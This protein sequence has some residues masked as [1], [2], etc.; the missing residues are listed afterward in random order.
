MHTHIQS[1]VIVV[2]NASTDGS[3]DMVKKEFP[4]VKLIESDK[5]LG[6]GLGNNLGVN[7]AVGE[8][9]MLFNSDALLTMDTAQEL[10]NYLEINNGVSCVCP[11]VVLPNTHV[12]QPKIFGFKP[13]AKTVLM[14]SFFLNRLFPKSTFF[15]GIDGDHRWAKKMNVG[16][17]SGVCMFMRKQHYQFVNGFDSRFFMYCEDIDLCLKL[18]KF[19]DII[20]YDDFEIIHYGGASSKTVSSVIRNSVWQQRHLLLIVK[21]YF[22]KTQWFLSAIAIF[23]GLILRLILGALVIP[24]YGIN[25]NLNLQSTWAR[26]LDLTSIKK[27]VFGAKSCS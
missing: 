26:I 27:Y 14:Q 2:D 1:E 23:F 15:R 9:V 11:R 24:K 10:V 18:E 16:W 7:H 12:I 25:E 13:T 21:E 20:F 6:F 3:V 19:G 4:T 8:Y 22:G 17:V 5:N